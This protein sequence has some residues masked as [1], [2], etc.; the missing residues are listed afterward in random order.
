MSHIEPPHQCS[1]NCSRHTEQLTEHGAREISAKFASAGGSPYI[2]N[3]GE[4]MV[5][6]IL[7]LVL[8]NIHKGLIED[9]LETVDELHNKVTNSGVDWYSGFEEEDAEDEL[10]DI[11]GADV[12]LVMDWDAA[13]KVAL[14]L[15][16]GR[17]FSVTLLVDSFDKGEVLVVSNTWHKP[18]T[19]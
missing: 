18:L 15:L 17:G 14:N 2:R 8:Y 11:G 5:Q 9:V 7:K 3:A 16:R 1:W 12:D 4:M 19:Q 13:A 10:S 6:E